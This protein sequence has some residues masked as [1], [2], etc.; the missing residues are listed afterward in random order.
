MHHTHPEGGNAAQL[1]VGSAAAAATVFAGQTDES[2][3][4]IGFLASHRIAAH[5]TTDCRHRR[6][7]A[8]AARSLRDA[9]R[10]QGNACNYNCKSLH[11]DQGEWKTENGEN[12]TVRA[13]KY[14][15]SSFR[16]FMYSVIMPEY[17]LYLHLHLLPSVSA[18]PAITL[19]PSHL[20]NF[21]LLTSVYSLSFRH[22]LDLLFC[23][24]SL[25]L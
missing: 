14:H 22:C 15:L 23:L 5:S 13:L 7:H 2:S 16:V 6:L 25:H 1:G 12:A 21:F 10:C 19:P 20:P 17:Y 8:Q 9:M 24:S 4:S 18:L 11:L 3:S